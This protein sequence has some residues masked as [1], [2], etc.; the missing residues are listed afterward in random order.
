MSVQVVSKRMCEHNTV[1]FCV[2]CAEWTL[3]PPRSTDPIMFRGPQFSPP[4]QRGWLCPRC[5]TVYAPWVPQCSCSVGVTT[6]GE[7]KMEGK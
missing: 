5:E 1:G 2:Q 7:T 3:P 4:V 6:D